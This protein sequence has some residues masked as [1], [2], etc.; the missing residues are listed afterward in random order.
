[1]NTSEIS[2]PGYT[3]ATVSFLLTLFSV[4]ALFIVFLFPP[5]YR[6]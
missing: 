3:H 2:W 5:H 6:A 1:M 4:E